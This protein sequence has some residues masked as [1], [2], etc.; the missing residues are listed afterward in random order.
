MV[1]LDRHRYAIRTM[2]YYMRPTCP[3]ANVTNA[4]MDIV[5]LG[6]CK[7]RGLDYSWPDNAQ[8]HSA[9][10]PASAAPSHAVYAHEAINKKL[11]HLHKCLCTWDRNFC[12]CKVFQIEVLRWTESRII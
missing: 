3:A 1:G 4:A 5:P 8:E 11:D 9:F 6:H 12:F 10:S 2:A 7:G